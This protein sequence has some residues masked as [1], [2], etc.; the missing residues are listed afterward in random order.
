ML[1]GL[2]N[3]GI[4]IA[5]ISNPVWL[6][7]LVLFDIFYYV[8]FCRYCCTIAINW[9]FMEVHYLNPWKESLKIE[10][11]DLAGIEYRKAYYDLFSGNSA[12]FLSQ[13]CFDRLILHFK[14]PNKHA[15]LVNINTLA[16]GLDKVFKLL[17]SYNKKIVP[18]DMP[19]L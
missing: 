17:A 1:L 19:L 4:L 15:V 8:M 18:Y 7:Y 12:R 10:I 11:A 9:Q 2:I 13:Y 3:L 14:D 6:M 5:A 16:F